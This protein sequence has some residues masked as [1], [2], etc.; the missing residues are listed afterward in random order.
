MYSE[1]N[2]HFSYQYGQRKYCH[3]HTVDVILGGQV[4]HFLNNVAH[5]E[6][7]SVAK[8]KIIPPYIGERDMGL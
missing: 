2:P 7:P 8:D 1:E 3:L 4:V 6:P 5:L